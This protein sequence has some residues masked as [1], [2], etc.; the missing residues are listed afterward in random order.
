MKLYLMPGACSLAAHIVLEWVGAKYET[1]ALTHDQI[2][3]PE[4]LARNPLGAVPA[5]EVEGRILTQNNAIL[6]YLAEIHPEA[7]LMGGNA[8]DRAEVNRWLG[9]ANSDIHPTFKPIFGATAFLEDPAII[10]KT[11]AQAR[12]RLRMLFAQIDQQL[13]GRD[14]IAGSRSIADPYVFVVTSWAR[15][16]GVDLNGLD[17]LNRYFDRM[18]VDPGVQAAMTAEGL[19]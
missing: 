19:I 3:Q 11:K 6:H 14:W 7:G 17:N 12:K 2:K 1:Q 13:A 4:F 15:N 16:T 10:D 8:L 9:F 18:A 5:F